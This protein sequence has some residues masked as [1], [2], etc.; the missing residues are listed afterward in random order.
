[1]N[2]NF[3]AIDLETANFNR[4]SIC[5]IGISIVHD[6]EIIETK[7]WLVQPEGN[8]YNSLN[9]SIHGIHPEDT[10]SAPS[11]AE[12]WKEVLPYLQNN[13]VVAHNT[14]FDMYAIRDALI[15]NNIEF[16][17]FQYYCSLR[18]A[19]Y[20]FHNTYSYSLPILCEAMG[21]PFS[22]HHRAGGDAEGCAKVFIH[23]MELAGVNSLE[24]LQTKYMF[25]CGEFRTG[26]FVAQLAKHKNS[27]NKKRIDISQI[28][29]DSSLID[30]GNYFYDK[31]VCFTGKC[32]YG[33][34]AELLQKIADIGGIPM[35]SVTSKT[36]VLVVGQQDYRV[37]GSE[38]ISGKQKKAMELKD[39]G[40]D[41]EI[42]SETEFLEMI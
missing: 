29:G 24:E 42:L 18:V 10:A 9:I 6:S 17:T 15:E 13:I 7:N 16:P 23:S 4:S 37:V 21:I 8:L 12:V 1:M 3:V 38:G 30:E 39:K 20:T 2:L 35:D 22:V 41:I 5:E 36:D 31:T 25:H 27:S 32:Q 19:R 33:T 34:R 11:F 40:Q 28:A 14:S 26:A